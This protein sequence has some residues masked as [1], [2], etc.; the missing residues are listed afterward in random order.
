MKIVVF[1]ASI[2]KNSINQ[3][4]ASYVAKQFKRSEIEEI[5][6]SD[7]E[8]PIYSIDRENELGIPSVI[9]QFISKIESADLIIISMAEHNGSYTAAFKNTFDWA[10]RRKLKMFEEKKMLLLSTA[11]GPR[12]GSSVLESALIR[13]PRHGADILASFSLPLFAE[14]FSDQIGITS[15]EKNIELKRIIKDVEQHFNQ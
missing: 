13:F 8:A 5:L 2:S 14:N 10:S 1:G 4:F 12:G 7:F 9:D 3:R 11:P 6:L 15:D